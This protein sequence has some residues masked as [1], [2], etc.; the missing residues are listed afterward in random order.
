M[1][2][3]SIRFI[4]LIGAVIGWFAII[5][6]LYLIIA[7]RVVSVPGT[8]LRFF[9]FFTINTN[10]LVALCFTFIFL[11]SK[12]RL[13]KFFQQPSTIT[14]I[15]VYITIVG[16]VYN[17]ILRSTWDPQGLA[18][19]ADELLHSLI[20]VLFIFFWLLFVPFVNVTEIGYN[21]ALLNA[22]GVL[23]VIFLLSLALIATG[24]LM[25]KFDDGKKKVVS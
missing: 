7:N 2:K 24:K 8:L 6:Q 25:K 20:P 14:A 22:G 13:G 4:S 5:I 23:L 19:V 12:S 9:S 16:I 10:I 1:Q 21:K 3:Q 18:M 15:V 17:V 11:K